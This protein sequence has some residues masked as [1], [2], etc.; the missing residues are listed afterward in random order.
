M[1]VTADFVKH[2]VG[3]K[4]PTIAEIELTLFENCNVS[5][6]FCGHDKKSTVGLSKQE[7][8]SKIPIVEKFIDGIDHG[9]NQVNLHLVGGEL[10][11]DRLINKK[12][13]ILES[14]LD[15]IKEY[16]VLCN[17]KGIEANIIVVTNF[18]M[19]EVVKVKSWLNDARLFANV[20]FVASYDPFGRPITSDY[21]KNLKF[22]KDDISNINVVV[23]KQSIEAL[24][25]GDKIFDSLYKEF[26]IFMDEFL[27]DKGTEY[28]IPSDQDYR[29]YLEM[30]K[31]QYPKLMPYGQA[32]DYLESNQI[33][34]LQFTTFNKCTIFPDGSVSNYLWARHTQDLFDIE[35]DSYDN[36]NMVFNFLQENNCFSCEYYQACPLRCPVAYSWKNR[37]RDSLCVVKSFFD[38]SGAEK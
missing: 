12:E 10:L 34:Q 4:I 25:K 14:Y 26:P 1:E 5:C 9:I 32:L 6:A 13:S 35:I 29:S 36:S 22:F 17:R 28:L 37:E 16:S 3:Q 18:L 2:L 24:K 27:P 11:Q 38:S 20:S 23:T 33:N 30:T 19:K 8:L 31:N 7:I 21:L 15:L